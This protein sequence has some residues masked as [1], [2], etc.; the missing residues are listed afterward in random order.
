MN[1]F[2]LL[3][4]ALFCS[5]LILAQGITTGSMSGLI[6][7]KDGTLPGA[8]IVA[9]HTPSGSQYGA[10]TDVDGAFKLPYLRVGGPYEVIISFLGYEDYVEKNI[11]ISLGQDYQLD[12]TLGEQQEVLDEVVV[13]AR[14][15]NILN[16]DKAGSGTNIN[17]QTL[18]AIP[19]I[20][21]SIN[22][23]T[24]LTPQASGA[25]FAGFSGLGLR[26]SNVTVDGSSFNNAYGLGG[27]GALVIGNAAGSEP[28]SLDALSEIQINLSPYDV[29]QGGF[30]GANINA[31]TRSGD[32]E[33]RAS[34]YSFFQNENLVGTQAR[35]VEVENAD[36]NTTQYGF[37]L[38]GPL[39]KNKLFFFVNYERVTGS[40]PASNFIAAEGSN[41]GD[42]VT[43]VSATDL[44]DIRQFLRNQY[45]YETGEYQGF[46]LNNSSNK[47]LIKLDYNISNIHKLSMR[48]N[49]LDATSDQPPSNSTF[50]GAGGRFDNPNGMSF[51]NTGWQRNLGIRSFVTELNSLFNNKFA[52]RLLVSYSSF[53]EDRSVNGELF[54]A[55]DIQQNGQTYIAFGSDMF[56]NNNVVN[57]NILQ[58]QNDFN[59]YLPKHTITL[60]MN[61]QH[62]R[63]KNG[64]TPASQGNFV[65]ASLQDFYNSTPEG[66]NTP[67]GVSDGMG[68]PSSY[69]RRYSG[70]ANREIV[71][72]EPRFAQTSFYVQDKFEVS[73]NFK[74]T[75]GLRFDV[76]S[77]LN[78][79]EKN[80]AL[81]TLNFQEPNGNTIQL[82]NSVLPG[83]QVVISPRLGFNW[84]VRGNRTFQIR[85]GIGVFNGISPFV[86]IGDTY[87]TNG[88]NQGEIRSFSFNGGTDN[89]PFSDDVDAYIPEFMG[90]RSQGDVNFV[91]PDFKMPRILKSTLGLDYQLPLGLVGSVEMIYGKTLYDLLPTNAN[92]DHTNAAMEGIDDRYR[93]SN[94]RIN[95]PVVSS[96]YILGNSTDGRQYNFSAKL[97][98]PFRNNWTAT[99]AY[100]Y[101]NAKDRTTFAG[102]GTRAAWRA[103]PVLGNTNDPALAFSDADQPHRIIGAAAYQLAYPK[104]GATTI[105]LFFEGAQNGR[106]SYQYS[107]LVFQDANGDFITND[108]IFVPADQSQI[109]VVDYE[110]NGEI[111]TAAEQWAALDNFISQSDYLDSRRGEFAE[112]NGAIRPWYFQADLR[113]LQDFNLNIGGKKNTLQVSLDILNFTN[114]LNSDWGV[115]DLPANTRPIQLI[116]TNGGTTH[117]VVP[118]TLGDEFRTDLSANSRWRM[119]LGVRYIFN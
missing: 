14:K 98:R 60:G 37:R 61:F 26:T 111:I 31:I 88:I 70:L 10:V 114:L 4:I 93:F 103:L 50:F 110:N 52:N 42:D 41:S 104:I 77:F 112:R 63:F 102:S 45:G 117:R 39:V 118:T 28:I 72:A 9:V 3:F 33:F 91:D 109:N 11:N 75:G 96:A 115:R 47:F 86:P 54:P 83:T 105:S 107:G 8:N 113:V 35:D 65:F 6:S 22:D 48:Y 81:D 67:I 85:G 99:L 23:F 25:D 78:E 58:I 87:L 62:Y 66:T 74:I 13:L 79:P 7:D 43:R 30:T 106:F 46:N 36:F 21:R 59:I 92:L 32:N 17:Q 116:R 1:K 76:T 95:H 20:N 68:R 84:D 40:T 5:Q 82:D 73:R 64:F 12:V 94:S 24:K 57:Q 53:P 55:V 19:Q 15:S 18:E 119:Q 69:A 89:I 34:V 49:Q 56:A 16:S 2:L 71:F 44:N 100:A 27:S 101:G 90:V 97:E 38:G 51:E 80:P 108:L 29:R